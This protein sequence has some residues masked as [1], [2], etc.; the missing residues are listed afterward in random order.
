MKDIRG[1]F[2]VVNVSITAINSNVIL[3]IARACA[4]R[5]GDLWII[6]MGNNEVVGPF[7][8]ATVFG[9]K[10][11]PLWAIRLSLAVEQTRVGQLIQ[12][13]TRR[14]KGR[15]AEASWGGMQMFLGNQIRSEDPR[16]ETVY[17]NFERNLRDIVRAGLNSGAKI[18]LSTVAVNLRDSAPFA[19]LGDTHLAAGDR[20][21][22]ER[23]R[24]DGDLAER[25]GNFAQAA[26][27]FEEA[28]R[29]DPRMAEVQFGW[30]QSL[31]EI[32]QPAPAA[33]KFQLAC[34]SDALP[35]RADSRI[36]GIIRRTGRQWGDPNLALLDSAAV[37]RVGAPSGILG[38]E[39]FYEHVHF[40]FDGNYRLALAWAEQ[41]Q[42]MLPSSFARSEATN[43]ASQ[44]VCERRLGLTDW[45]RLLVVKSVLER[46]QAPPLSSRSN[47]PRQREALQEELRRLSLEA[48]PVNAAGARNVYLEAIQRSPQDPF[49]HENY[50]EFLQ[51]AGDLSGAVEQWT[52]VRALQPQDPVAAFQCGHVLGLKGK[53]MDAQTSLVEAISL[54]PTMEEAW[55]ELGKARFALGRYD[56]A[57]H[58]FEAARELRPNDARILCE[59]G[60][61]LSLLKRPDEA[62]R[63]LERAV[64]SRFLQ[65]GSAIRAGGQLGLMN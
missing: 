32:A 22:F 13:L 27:R 10:A 34:D 31:L 55:F 33:E 49:L 16:R 5:H 17:R 58:D 39:T 36:N 7:G 61:A 30:G 51:S 12:A 4:A 2:E 29:I 45:N 20:A 63:S 28:A 57:L 60:R 53:W 64:S 18:L 24:A 48:I 40:N 9:A 11:P 6:Y 1:A 42:R 62:L 65:R 15:S 59:M 26:L 43:W 25:Q 47:A 38:A 21:A 52:Q 44:A 14:L 54:R 23:S 56:D 35:F 41:V 3:P 37:L 50:A 8:A 19:S 46:L